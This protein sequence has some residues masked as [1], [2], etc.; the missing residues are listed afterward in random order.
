MYESR[1]EK[2]RVRS[3]T[4]AGLGIKGVLESG[5]NREDFS[6]SIKLHSVEDI[7]WRIWAL[8]NLDG[9]DYITKS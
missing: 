6:V 9:C 4:V 5:E 8:T 7:R 1:V 3:Q 2:P